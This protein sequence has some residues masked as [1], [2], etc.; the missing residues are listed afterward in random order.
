ME[1]DIKPFLEGQE[2]IPIRKIQDFLKTTMTDEDIIVGVVKWY[3]SECNLKKFYE[4]YDGEVFKLGEVDKDTPI[5][6]YLRK[7]KTRDAR[8]LCKEIFRATFFN[9]DL[10]DLEWPTLCRFFYHSIIEDTIAPTM[11]IKTFKRMMKTANFLVNIKEAKSVITVETKTSK[12]KFKIKKGRVVIYERQQ[13]PRKKV[14]NV[15]NKN[16]RD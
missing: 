9:L 11:D 5:R 15:E 6:V 2:I 4:T 8:K 14:K 16:Y 1:K 13:L 7:A 3:K 12:C 10:F